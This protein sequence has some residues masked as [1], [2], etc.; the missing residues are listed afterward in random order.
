MRTIV[1]AIT[2]STPTSREIGQGQPLITP[3]DTSND[4]RYNGVIIIYKK[5]LNVGGKHEQRN[6]LVK[7][8]L[9]RGHA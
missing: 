8:E 1:D 9:E 5:Y 6:S 7:N 3:R 2:D 4:N